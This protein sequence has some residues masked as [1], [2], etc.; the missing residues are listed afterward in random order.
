MKAILESGPK[1][2]ITSEL[3]SFILNVKTTAFPEKILRIINS[4]TI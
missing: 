1:I 3:A 2:K 4:H